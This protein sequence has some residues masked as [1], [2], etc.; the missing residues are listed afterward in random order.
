MKETTSPKKQLFDHPSFQSAEEAQSWKIN[1]SE[2]VKTSE[3]A[4]INLSDIENE[5]EIKS[6]LDGDRRCFIPTVTEEPIDYNEIKFKFSKV[7]KYKTELLQF[8]KDGILIKISSVKKPHHVDISLLHRTY[9]PDMLV[10]Q[11]TMTSAY[12]NSMF[13]CYTANINTDKFST[14]SFF[15]ES[16]FKG[17]TNSKFKDYIYI[18]IDE[19]SKTK[20]LKFSLN[21]FIHYQKVKQVFLNQ[22]NNFLGNDEDCIV[23]MDREF[24]VDK[25]QDLSFLMRG[26]NETLFNKPGVLP[27]VKTIKASCVASFFRFYD[28]MIGMGAHQDEI[29]TNEQ[30]AL[31]KKNPKEF[32]KTINNLINDLAEHFFRKRKDID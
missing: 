2:K 21:E 4:M 26:N 1:F 5:R 24:Y 12:F 3:H 20:L 32:K 13:R 7:K 9:D 29:I 28:K 25:I 8:Y 10:Q 19:Y 23:G 22:K 31:F 11:T 17:W 18:L 30:K 14:Q 16:S 6:Y 27:A 15:G